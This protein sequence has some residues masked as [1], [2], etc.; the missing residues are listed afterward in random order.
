[1]NEYEKQALDFL[2]KTGAKV[3][4]RLSSNQ[5][6]PNWDCKDMRLGRMVVPGHG[7]K[8]EVTIS[9]ENKQAFTFDFWSSV[10]DSYSSFAKKYPDET[11]LTTWFNPAKHAKKP[12]N[13]DILACISGDINGHESTFSEFCSEFGYNNDSIRAKGIYES[14]CDQA[15]SLARLFSQD[16]LMELQEIN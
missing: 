6:K 5:T 2:E 16:E 8:Y 10:N 14:V 12:T 15:R 4:V 13:Y 7:L 1:M 3:A 9:R 11:K